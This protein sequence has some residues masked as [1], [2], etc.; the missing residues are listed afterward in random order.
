MKHYR[1]IGHEIILRGMT[2]L[3]QIM[4]DT[5]KVQVDCIDHKWSHGWHETRI[6]DW[7]EIE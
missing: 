2:A 5:F 3:G 1:Y 7:E 4:D 6:W